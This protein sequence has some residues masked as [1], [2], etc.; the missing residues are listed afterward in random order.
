MGVAE[1]SEFEKDLTFYIHLQFK[2]EHSVRMTLDIDGSGHGSDMAGESLYVDSQR[3]DPSTHSLGTD[4][5]IVDSF[6]K[7]LFHVCVERVRIVSAERLS[8]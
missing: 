3:C 5:E 8:Q 4:P 6:Q 7:P 2:R 1:G